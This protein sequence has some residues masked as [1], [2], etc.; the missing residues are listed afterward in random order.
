MFTQ[1]EV[2]ANMIKVFSASEIFTRLPLILVHMYTSP[3]RLDIKFRYF[4]AAWV[5]INCISSRPWPVAHSQQAMLKRGSWRRVGLGVGVL[6]SISQPK[7]CLNPSSQSTFF[8]NPFSAH[9]HF[10]FVIPSSLRA[11]L[12]CLVFE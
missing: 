3:S 9:S 11:P 10:L 1:S 5:Y 8:P 12:K 2:T 7:H 6:H 4:N